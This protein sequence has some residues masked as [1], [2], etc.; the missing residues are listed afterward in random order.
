M[1]LPFKRPG[2]HDCDDDDD[3]LRELRKIEKLLLR[4]LDAL[5]RPP[6]KATVVGSGEA[7]VS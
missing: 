5:E 7:R 6:F 3:V 1:L 2:N 4:I